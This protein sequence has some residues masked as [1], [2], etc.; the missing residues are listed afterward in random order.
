MPK[1]GGLGQCADLRGGLGKK[2]GGVDTPMYTM[3]RV[4]VPYKCFLAILLA[5]SI[6]QIQKLGFL[7]VWLAA[8]LVA[9]IMCGKYS[10]LHYAL[11]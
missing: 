8:S 11:D 9:G 4:N 1:K 7:S 6:P 5:I 10:C 2:E 3:G